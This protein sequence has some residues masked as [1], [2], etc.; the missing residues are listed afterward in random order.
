MPPRGYP[1]WF[2][3]FSFFLFSFLRC[4]LRFLGQ[5]PC[6]LPACLAVYKRRKLLPRCAVQSPACCW[7]LSNSRGPGASLPVSRLCDLTNTASCRRNTR[8][9]RL[10]SRE[11]VKRATLNLQG[12]RHIF[13][14][15]KTSFK[16]RLWSREWV[17]R[18]LL[19]LQRVRHIL[20]R[21]RPEK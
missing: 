8:R 14:L 12:V 5:Q 13:S 20:R 10:W 4:T 3:P 19:H 11:W 18:E 1:S 17:K 21:M 16:P 7:C 9:P 6:S 15:Q 2:L